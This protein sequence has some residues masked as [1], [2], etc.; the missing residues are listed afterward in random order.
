MN[1]SLDNSQYFLQLV[2]TKVKSTDMNSLQVNLLGACVW[3]HSTAQRLP[4]EK[5][6]RKLNSC[7]RKEAAQT[8]CTT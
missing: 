1:D 8:I 3:D 5:A 6:D 7:V 4:T 2:T